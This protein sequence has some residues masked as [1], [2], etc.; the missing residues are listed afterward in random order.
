MGV[1][2]ISHPN[3]LEDQFIKGFFLD[4]QMFSWDTAEG[5]LLV[6]KILSFRKKSEKQT[7]FIFFL[8]YYQHKFLEGGIFN[9]VLQL[10]PTRQYTTA[11]ENGPRVGC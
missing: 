7:S 1:M 8:V 5:C 6:C 3:R 2:E 10:H 11:C 9:W 4:I